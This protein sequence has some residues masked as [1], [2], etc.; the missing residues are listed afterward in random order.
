ML[1]RTVGLDGMVIVLVDML[2]VAGERVR[3]I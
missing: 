2:L 1:V 3:G